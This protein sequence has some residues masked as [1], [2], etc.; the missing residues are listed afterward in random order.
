MVNLLGNAIR[1]SPDNGEIIIEASPQDGTVEIS[2]I[3]EGPGVPEEY[4][5][6]IFERYQQVPG[7][8]NG[9][10]GLGLAICKAILAQ[11]GSAIMV[12]DAFPEGKTG[13]KFSF[14]LVSDAAPAAEL[15]K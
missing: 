12:K 3:D 8:D 2:V 4:R 14:V 5:Q 9:G 13:S 15:P 1:H 6:A 7:K 11:H 10:T